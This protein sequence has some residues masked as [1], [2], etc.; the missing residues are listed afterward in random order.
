VDVRAIA[1]TNRDLPLNA[2]Q[3]GAHPHD[4]VMAFA[5]PGA[6]RLLDLEPS[7]LRFRIR[8]LGIQKSDY[9]T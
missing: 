3:F 2:A 8:K 5:V 9:R 1:A 6:A 4:A 7:T